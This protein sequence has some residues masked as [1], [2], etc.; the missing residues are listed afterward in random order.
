VPGGFG[1]ELVR[2][3]DFFIAGGDVHDK[4][5]WLGAQLQVYLVLG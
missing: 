1:A 5:L 4:M 3:E 2:E